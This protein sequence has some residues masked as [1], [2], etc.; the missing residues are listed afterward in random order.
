MT[1]ACLSFCAFCAEDFESILLEFLFDQPMIHKLYDDML[2]L[3]KNLMRK[4]IK[5]NSPFKANE[6]LKTGED[7]LEID[8][9]RAANHKSL[10]CAETG[11]KATLHFNECVLLTY[12]EVFKFR[13]ECLKFY[14]AAAEYLI[15]NVPVDSALIKYA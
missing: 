1:E 12:D 8:L 10:S 13:R 9:S 11:T 15:K 5:K 2:T 14:S 6:D 3:L 4:F 7:L